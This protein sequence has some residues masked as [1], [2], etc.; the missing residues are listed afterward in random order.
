M[1]FKPILWV[2]LEAMSITT[3]V[4]V[5]DIYMYSKFASILKQ[6]HFSVK[7]GHLKICCVLNSKAYTV[8]TSRNRRSGQFPHNT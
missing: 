5:F 8:G 6:K 3:G 2:S 1:F 4:F 7:T